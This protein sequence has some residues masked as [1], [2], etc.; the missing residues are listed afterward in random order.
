MASRLVP[1]RFDSINVS[2]W[3]E[4]GG[5][6]SLFN[7]CNMSAVWFV[8]HVELKGLY[9]IFSPILAGEG[10]VLNSEQSLKLIA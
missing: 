2:F 10:L 5:W 9:V 1:S 7:M 6:L 8:D 4:W 3:N